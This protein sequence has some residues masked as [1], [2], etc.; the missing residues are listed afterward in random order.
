MS[1]M[2][3]QVTLATVIAGAASIAASAPIQA[4]SAD[5]LRDRHASQQTRRAN[6]DDASRARAIHECSVA[7]KKRP[8]QSWGGTRLY[9][10]QA[11]MAKHGEPE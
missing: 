2:I 1:R 3:A 8:H 5:S 10:Y 7:Q 9:T 4:V 11:C 6:L